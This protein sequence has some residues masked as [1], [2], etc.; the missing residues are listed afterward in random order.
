MRAADQQ[1][2]APRG[3]FAAMPAARFE[4]RPVIHPTPR[5]EPRPVAHPTPRFEPRPI[6]R[7]SKTCPDG[8][9]PACSAPCAPEHPR[10]GKSPI[11][12]PWKVLPWEKPLPPAPVVKVV[13]RRPDNVN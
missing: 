9:L 7:A 12:P 2:G 4:P 13:I 5:F 6:E 10:I 11:Q 1:A 8:L 3:G